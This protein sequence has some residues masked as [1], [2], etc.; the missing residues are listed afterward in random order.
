MKFAILGPGGIA[1]KM[2]YTVQQL[3]GM[4]LYAVASRDYDRAKAFAEKWGFEKAYGSYEEMVEDPEIELI[5]I[6]T[7]HLCR[8]FK[9]HTGMT[10]SHYINHVKLQHGCELLVHTNMSITEIA[11]QC[12]FNSSMYFC[13]TFKSQMGCTPTE[14]R[15]ATGL[16]KY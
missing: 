13:K 2:A 1:N 7:P 10:V 6:S 4:E 12:G 14:F 11:L 5:Y 15:E 8:I 16:P 9:K 3:E